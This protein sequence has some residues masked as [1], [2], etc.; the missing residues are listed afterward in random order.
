MFD[1][2]KYFAKAKA[3]EKAQNGLNNVDPEGG[4]GRGLEESIK[5]VIEFVIGLVGI[6]AVI[7][8]IIGGIN[9]TMSQGDPAKTKKAKDTILYG[10]I[11]LIVS[12]AA[13][14]IVNFVLTAME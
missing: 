12:I 4:K 9:Y 10:V 1:T 6:I 11:G 2:I 7:M 8:I 3:V 13:F 14:A 5:V